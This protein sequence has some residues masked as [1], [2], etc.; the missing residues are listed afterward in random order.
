MPSLSTDPRDADAALTG[1]AFAFCVARRRAVLPRF[2][3]QL[4]P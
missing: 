2:S 3:E 1:G 4:R